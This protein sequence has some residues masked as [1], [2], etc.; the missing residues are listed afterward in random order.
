MGAWICVHAG[1]LIGVGILTAFVCFVLTGCI[2]AGYDSSTT[3]ETRP[4]GTVVVTKHRHGNYTDTRAAGDAAM[5]MLGEIDW[6]SLAQNPLLKVAGGVFGAGALTLGG[7]IHSRGK[8]VGRNQ[9]RA[10]Q[11][12][13][14]V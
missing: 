5:G 11:H 7:L 9:V 14:T 10:A 13:A 6:Q 2:A 12:K 3:T 1:A 4:D 8:S